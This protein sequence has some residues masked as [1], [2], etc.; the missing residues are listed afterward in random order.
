MLVFWGLCILSF[1]I[2][3][4]FRFRDE[5]S[6]PDQRLFEYSTRPRWFPRQIWL[7]NF[8]KYLRAWYFILN[9]VQG[10]S[11]GRHVD[12]NVWWIKSWSANWA[13]TVDV[14]TKHNFMKF[15]KVFIWSF[16]LLC[17]SAR[18]LLACS[19]YSICLRKNFLFLMFSNDVVVKTINPLQVQ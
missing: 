18:G 5:E 17:A 11:L 7:Y 1:P 6:I 8:R 15:V 13:I 9:F 10:L 16:C 19:C 3:R 14:I 12:Y 2:C 4:L